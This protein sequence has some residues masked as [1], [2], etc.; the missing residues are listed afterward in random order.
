MTAAMRI[1]RL[2]DAFTDRIGKVVAFL[3]VLLTLAL[4]FE[5]FSR[6]LF[7]APTIWAYDATYILSGT[8][9]M[10]GAAYALLYGAHIRTDM[11]YRTLS[12][13]RQGLLDA[14]LYLVFFFPGMVFFLLAGYEYAYR[15]W[16]GGEQAAVSPWRPIIWPFKALLPI[17]AILVMIQGV[18]EFVKSVYA[19]V[20][21]RWPAEHHEEDVLG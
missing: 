19:A 3:V 6:Y 18:S 8:L 2:I 16:L 14:V 11:I 13:R 20:E 17:T 7:G 1:V 9:F 4:C 12:P 10:L 15:S 21:G 5:A